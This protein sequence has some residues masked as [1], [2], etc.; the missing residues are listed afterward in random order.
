M[1]SYGNKYNY[2]SLNEFPQL[3]QLGNKGETSA[4]EEM[5][6]SL[7]GLRNIS[8]WC[9]KNT[10]IGKSLAMAKLSAV[11]G[12]IMKTKIKGSKT[13]E[14]EGQKILDDFHLGMD[15]NGFVDQ[16][17]MFEIMVNSEFEKGDVL[18]NLPQDPNRVGI[19]TYVELIEASRVATPIEHER[20]PLI[21]NGVKHDK[22]GR[23]LGY[24]VMKLERVM[25]YVQYGNMKD[26]F[27]YFPAY[28]T[29]KR[30]GMTRLVT[31]LLKNPMGERANQT[32]QVPALDSATRYIRLLNKYVESVV[33]GAQVAACFAG[34]ISSS[35]PAGGK[36]GEL[37]K[38]P[39]DKVG[40]IDPGTIYFLK[41]GDKVDF[42]SPS[43]PADNSIAFMR[44]LLLMSASPVRI[45][46]EIAFLDLQGVSF[47]SFK[48]G[49]N[50]VVRN[51]NMWIKDLSAVD[52]W[53]NRTVLLEAISTGKLRGS[54][55]GTMIHTHFPKYQAVEEEKVARAQ[56][57][58][59]KNKSQSV[60]GLC[61][62]NNLDYEMITAQREEEELKDVEI[63][64]KVLI[65]KKEAEEKYDIIFP[66]GSP[67]A[68]KQEADEK[69]TRERE[70]REG[71]SKEDDE[72][73][74]NKERRKEDGNN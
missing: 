32:R 39:F 43:R 13:M 22:W 6:G 74:R 48:G 49:S 56:S 36:R 57:I 29:D 41:R 1:S 67:T 53:I 3:S 55:K 35:N 5:D 60:R 46:Y 40:K 63:E 68:A 21:R 51:N 2:N 71:E 20:N 73:E 42:S 31:Y 44:Q 7:S 72:G 14:T 17:K 27:D 8:T 38:S 15:I 65:A 47:S 52:Q 70:L 26:S 69:E 25:D 37:K 59:L 58:A 61:L 54:L 33:I 19:K 11:M 30:T 45:P 18:I 16:Q 28:I 10:P 4:D 64:T 23:V 50:E 9:I 62:E 34:F 66:E 12:G 24:Y